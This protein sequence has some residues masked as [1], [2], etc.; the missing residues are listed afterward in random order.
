[1]PRDVAWWVL[2]I[3]CEEEWLVKIVWSAYM[4]ARRGVRVNRAF[5]DDFLAQLDYIRVN[6]LFITV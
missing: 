4:N 3:L 6:C 2:R 5:S 1:M